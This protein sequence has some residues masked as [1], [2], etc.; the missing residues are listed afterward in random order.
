MASIE[1]WWVMRALT[2][3]AA[4]VLGGCGAESPAGSLESETVGTTTASLT[5]AE[6]SAACAAD[7]RVTAGLVSQQVCIGADLFFRETFDGNG[8]TCATCHRVENNYTI[9]PAFIATLPPS[10]P[11]FVAE[12]N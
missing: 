1:N 6:R 12:T 10:D 3:S 4:F 9:D 2:V 5:F 8:R 7:P 11:L